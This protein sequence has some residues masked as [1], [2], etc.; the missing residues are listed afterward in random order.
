MKRQTAIILTILTLSLTA[1]AQTPLSTSSD[2]AH[3][4][5]G[6]Y[7]AKWMQK[8]GMAVSN[9]EMFKAGIADVQNGKPLAIADSTIGQ[10]VAGY[11]TSIQL[12]QNIQMEQELFANLRGKQGV[13]ALPSGVH[14]IVI[15]KGEGKRPAASDTITFQAVGVFP[16]GTV[17]ENTIEKEQAITNITANL[18]PGLRDA[19]QLMPEGSTWRIF[20]P[21]AQGYG[22]KGVPNLI[23]P[24]MALVFEI[25]LEEIR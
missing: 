2:T 4:T 5:I 7:V 15:K 25:T 22:T 21:A 14:Y 20:V 1:Q 16:D 12:A 9:F 19:V 17:F 23:P 3:Y 24:N 10:R 8:N 13:G 6:A 18:I 11:Q